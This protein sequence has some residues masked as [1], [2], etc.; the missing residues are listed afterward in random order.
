MCQKMKWLG[1]A[2]HQHQLKQ[3]SIRYNV[4]DIWVIYQDRLAEVERQMYQLLATSHTNVRH[5]QSWQCL[6]KSLQSCNL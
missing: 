1:F 3:E 2:Y 6:D 4:L 5:S